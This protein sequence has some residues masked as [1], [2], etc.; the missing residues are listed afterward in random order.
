[1][2]WV[3]KSSLAL[4]MN[5]RSLIL[6]VLPAALF[7]VLFLSFVHWSKESSP[8][9]GDAKLKE[10][11]QLASEMSVPSSFREVATH[12]SSRAMDAGVHK[13]YHSSAS[14]EEVKKFYSD[15]LIARGWVLIAEQ[16]HESIL[17]DTDGKDLKFQKADIII[18][19]E[20]AGSRASDRSWNYSVSYVWHNS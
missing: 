14:F 4:S 12:S 1:M 3:V 8:N 11:Q 15:Q 18:S 7:L 9:R 16:N 10:L 19:I 17:I 20:H 2:S 6:K 13:S 5:V